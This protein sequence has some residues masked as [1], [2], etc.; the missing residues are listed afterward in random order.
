[1]SCSLKQVEKRDPD[2]KLGIIGRENGLYKALRYNEI[3]D[4]I[5]AA[6]DETGNLKHRYGDI[7][8]FLVDTK[9]LLHLC[10][11]SQQQFN[12]LYHKAYKRIE[13]VNPDSWET[14]ITDGENGWKF[15]L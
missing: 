13:H 7:L 14:V 6:E 2:E 15:E 8:V 11:A 10:G 5:K 3:T 12:T 9:F 1:M 4:A